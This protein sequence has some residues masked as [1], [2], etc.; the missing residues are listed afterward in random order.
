MN[1]NAAVIATTG[2]AV[3]AANNEVNLNAV[4]QSSQDAV[5]GGDTNDPEYANHTYNS[6]YIKPNQGA[7]DLGQQQL[8]RG[9]TY[10][11]LVTS[12]MKKD[13]VGTTLAGGGMIG[14]GLATGGSLAPVGMMG[15]GAAV[16]LMAN[17]GVQ[18]TGNQPFDW[19]GF[20]LAGA[21]GAASTGMKFVPVFLTGV[22]GALTGSALQGQNPNGAMVGAAAGTAIGYTIG[23]KIEG[24]LNDALNPWYR[25]EWQSIGMG[26]SKYVPP[27]VLPSW[28]GGAVGGVTQ[29]KAGGL[30]QNGL[31][32]SVN[33]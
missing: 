24:R 21:T 4:R 1:A 19:T 9:Q 3:L 27:S 5:S 11:D 10:N 33:K 2:D 20:A 22:G 31:N 28:L 7:Y 29:E 12:N 23:S 18:L 26:I 17:G 15:I 25:Q 14:L 6:Q 8:A 13:P 32:G 30:V 16:G